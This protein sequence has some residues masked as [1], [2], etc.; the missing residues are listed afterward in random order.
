M[1]ESLKIKDYS[2]D[3][4]SMYSTLGSTPIRNKYKVSKSSR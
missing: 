1:E 2:R 3:R 4:L